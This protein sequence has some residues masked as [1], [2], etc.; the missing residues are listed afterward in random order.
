MQALPV[1]GAVGA[2]ISAIGAI[3]GGEANA[4]QARYEAQVAKQ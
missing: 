3:S 1:I 2:G 4:A